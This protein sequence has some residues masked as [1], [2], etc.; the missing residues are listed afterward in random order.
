VSENQ[1]NLPTQPQAKTFLVAWLLSLLLGIF[2]VDRFY[3]G[4]VGTGLVKLFTLGGLGIWYLIDLIILLGNGTKDKNGLELEGYEKTKVTA[5]VVSGVVILA[6]AA[7]GATGDSDGDGGGSQA[8][9]SSSSSSEANETESEATVEDATEE[10]AVEDPDVQEE[11]E[12]S[13]GAGVG[14]TLRTDDGIDITLI[15]VQGPVETPNG[16]IIDD[17][18]GE[19]IAVEMEMFNDSDDPVNLS[20]S[21]VTAYIGNATY[22]ASALFG[23]NGDW[24]IFEDVN[25]KL[26][27]SFTAYFD[28][29]IGSGPTQIE[30][31]S[32]LFFGE[33][34]LF[35]TG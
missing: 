16:W 23:P 30:F 28:M 33:S 27:T 15:G 22:E 25:P 10:T 20:T 35:E 9:S 18:K 31:S 13:E 34:V 12:Q 29:P 8:S 24:F 26:G 1:A 7:L 32:S 17:P 11:P 14:D 2:G 19:L 5:W 6:A 4:K 21:S 3:L